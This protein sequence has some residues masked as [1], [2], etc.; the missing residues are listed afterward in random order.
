VRSS[1]VL[2]PFAPGTIGEGEGIWNR[3]RL[4]GEEIEG[5]A[6]FPSLTAALP[7]VWK[8]LLIFYWLRVCLVMFF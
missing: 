7:D 5:A 2:P 8:S 6:Q 4:V 1:L 3:A